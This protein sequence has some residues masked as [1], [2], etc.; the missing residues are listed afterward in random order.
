MPEVTWQD[1]QCA[2]KHRT[3]PGEPKRSGF[4]RKVFRDH[5]RAPGQCSAR[6]DHLNAAGAKIPN[7]HHI[8]R[9]QHRALDRRRPKG[10]MG[11]ASTRPAPR[12]GKSREP[13]PIQSKTKAK[14]TQTKANQSKR[15][16]NQSKPTQFIISDKPSPYSQNY[17]RFL[18]GSRNRSYDGALPG[19]LEIANR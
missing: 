9:P 3:R 14:P 12:T 7:V 8:M 11:H 10:R 1:G 15:K 17:P 4:W 18:S 6:Y 19:S 2:R 13:K 16:A 5:L